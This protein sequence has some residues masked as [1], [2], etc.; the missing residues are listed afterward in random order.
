MNMLSVL[1]TYFLQK[2]LGWLVE[3]LDPENFELSLWSG[4]VLLRNL[5]VKVDALDLL[6]L[7][8][9]VKS[10][11]LSL[12]RLKIPWRSLGSDQVVVEINGLSVIAVPKNELDAYDPEAE[13]VATLAAKEAAINALEDGATVRT[14][15]NTDPRS[16]DAED[17]APGIVASYIT[18]I[19]DNCRVIISD[20][21]V[22][23]EDS[24]SSDSPFTMGVQMKLL[25]LESVD[26]QWNVITDVTEKERD[27]GMIRKSVII[28]DL[29]LYLDPIQLDPKI[30]WSK[31]CSGTPS[32]KFILP[33]CSINVRLHVDDSIVG[34]AGP[35][36]HLKDETP[37]LSVNV[38]L[39]NINLRLSKVQY[40]NIM[41]FVAFSSTYSLRF[42]NRQHRPKSSVVHDPAAWWRYA[43]FSIRDSVRKKLENRS[44]NNLYKALEYRKKYIALYMLQDEGYAYKNGEKPLN[45]KNRKRQDE[46]KALE[47]KLSIDQVK[48]FRKHANDMLTEYRQKEFLPKNNEDVSGVLGLL[49]SPVKSLS[50]I[51]TGS[52]HDKPDR[53]TDDFTEPTSPSAKRSHKEV[54][55]VPQTVKSKRESLKLGMSIGQFSLCID[56]NESFSVIKFT[57]ELNL[58]R[59]TANISQS[60]SAMCAELS[61]GNIQVGCMNS[62][63]FV[64][65]P[66][67]IVGTGEYKHPS[68]SFKNHDTRRGQSLT[69]SQLHS[70]PVKPPVFHVV[71]ETIDNLPSSE[72]KNATA[73]G[74]HFDSSSENGKRKQPNEFPVFASL[75]ICLRRL[76]LVWNS[77]F[78]ESITNFI[79]LKSNTEAD[80]DQIDAIVFAAAAEARRLRNIGE[81]R[82]KDA[83]NSSSRIFVTGS[84]KMPD[85]ILATELSTTL[86]SEPMWS[87]RSWVLIRLGHLKVSS[88]ALLPQIL[89]DI[90][91][92]VES[93]AKESEEQVSRKALATYEKFDII[94]DDIQVLF[95]DVE[96]HE[97]GD[98]IDFLTV[99]AEFERCL[100]QSTV[101][102]P[103]LRVNIQL[104]NS[105]LNVCPSAIQSILAVLKMTRSGVD[106]V[107]E[108]QGS[109][110]TSTM[111]QPNKSTSFH[112]SNDLPDDVLED[113]QRARAE[114]GGAVSAGT[115]QVKLGDRLWL[116]KSVSTQ[117]VVKI[118]DFRVNMLDSYT[119]GDED[120]K[121]SS[122]SYENYIIATLKIM[123]FDMRLLQRTYDTAILLEVRHFSLSDCI[124]LYANTGK[125]NTI[126]GPDD[127]L[128]DK[129]FFTTDKCVRKEKQ[130]KIDRKKAGKR[131]FCT[132]TQYEVSP[133]QDPFMKLRVTIIDPESPS[134]GVKEECQGSPRIWAKFGCLSLFVDGKRIKQLLDY[135]AK[136]IPSAVNAENTETK[137]ESASNED[138]STVQPKPNETRNSKI[139]DMALLLDIDIDGIGL[140]I[141]GSPNALHCQELMCA[142]QNSFR[143]L[144]IVTKLS[145]SGS[146]LICQYW[147][148]DIQV[149]DE[150]LSE[151]NLY[152]AMISMDIQNAMSSRVERIDR[153]NSRQLM[154]ASKLFSDISWLHP[155]SRGPCIYNIICGKLQQFYMEPESTEYPG[156]PMVADVSLSNVQIVYRA[157]AVSSLI[158]LINDHA[159]TLTNP[160]NEELPSESDMDL[161]DRSTLGT[162]PFLRIKIVDTTLVVPVA[163][164]L[165]EHLCVKIPEL[166][167]GNGIGG[168]YGF[169]VQSMPKC[170]SAFAFLPKQV[171]HVD[172]VSCEDI[173]LPLTSDDLSKFLLGS[174]VSGSR[175]ESSAT[176]FESNF[177][178]DEFT[179][180]EGDSEI[181]SESD[182]SDEFDYFDANCHSDSKDG[183][184][185]YSN[186]V[187]SQANHRFSK[188]LQRI[189]K[190]EEQLKEHRLLLLEEVQAELSV[191]N[192]QIKNLQINIHHCT[193]QERVMY[194]LHPLTLEVCISLPVP[195]VSS[196]TRLSL[197]GSK[198]DLSLSAENLTYVNGLIANNFA[199]EAILPESA[200]GNEKTLDLKE[201]KSHMDGDSSTTAFDFSL[202]KWCAEIDEEWIQDTV[203]Y[204]RVKG[205]QV[206]II[207]ELAIS[208]DSSWV[209]NRIGTLNIGPIQV[210]YDADSIHKSSKIIVGMDH[211]VLS[212]NNLSTFPSDGE[213]SIGDCHEYD[214]F[215]L[216]PEHGS[217]KAFSLCFNLYSYVTN[218]H[219]A[220]IIGNHMHLSLDVA[221][222]NMHTCDL[223]SSLLRLFTTSGSDLDSKF[224]SEKNPFIGTFFPHQHDPG[225]EESILP[226]GAS[227]N[228]TVNFDG[229]AITLHDTLSLH[230]ALRIEL[231]LL[232]QAQMFNDNLWVSAQGFQFQGKSYNSDLC[233]PFIVPISF[234]V[235]YSSEGNMKQK[236]K[237]SLV[238]GLKFTARL[239]HYNILNNAISEMMPLSGQER[240]QENNK[241]NLATA[242]KN[243]EEPLSSIGTDNGVDLN[244]SQA[245]LVLD[246]GETAATERESPIVQFELELGP[247]YI[248]ILN[249]LGRG[250]VPL[251]RVIVH[252]PAKHIYNSSQVTRKI[253]QT[254]LHS[255]LS[256]AID[257]FNL[258]LSSWEPLLEMCTMKL[259]AY[260]PRLK[261]VKSSRYNTNVSFSHG[262]LSNL[263]NVE[264]NVEVAANTYYR[265]TAPDILNLNMS[266]S[267]LNSLFE[268]IALVSNTFDDSDRKF[269]QPEKVLN[270]SLRKSA[271]REYLVVENGLG[272]NVECWISEDLDMAPEKVS[273]L[274]EQERR[275]ARFKMMTDQGWHCQGFSGNNTVLVKHGNA[276]KIYAADENAALSLINENENSVLAF[277]V[278]D[279]LG[280]THPLPPIPIYRQACYRRVIDKLGESSQ[281]NRYKMSRS[282]L[283]KAII[284]GKEST[285]EKI[286][287]VDIWK[288]QA[289][290]FTCQVS[291]DE[292]IN[293]VSLQSNLA[294]KNTLEIGICIIL[295][296]RLG[297]QSLLVEPGLVQHLPCSVFESTE[298][299]LKLKKHCPETDSDVNDNEDSCCQLDIFAQASEAYDFG[300][301]FASCELP[302]DLGNFRACTT[303]DID[304]SGKLE[305]I[306]IT[307]I[308]SITI[309]NL[310]PT[311]MVYEMVLHK[312]SSFL[313]KGVVEKGRSKSLL[314]DTSAIAQPF[315]DLPMRLVLSFGISNVEEFSKGFQTEEIRHISRDAHKKIYKWQSVSA[316]IA[317]NNPVSKQKMTYLEIEISSAWKPQRKPELRLSEEAKKWVPLHIRV[318]APY[319]I[320]NRTE[321]A[322]DIIP[323]GTGA[324]KDIRGFNITDPIILPEAMNGEQKSA[325][326]SNI[327]ETKDKF[328][329]LVYGSGKKWKRTSK[330]AIRVH[331]AGSFS[332]ESTPIPLLSVGVDQHVTINSTKHGTFSVGI[333]VV[334]APSPFKSLIVT[335]CPRYVLVNKLDYPIALSQQ[336]NFS[337][338]IN[339]QPQECQTF[340]WRMKNMPRHLSVKPLCDE[341]VSFG[342]FRGK[343]DYEWSGA[344]EIDRVATNVLSIHGW[345][346]ETFASKENRTVNGLVGAKESIQGYLNVSTTTSV[347]R[348]WN[349]INGV[350]DDVDMQLHQH[351]H[352]DNEN[353]V[354]SYPPGVRSFHLKRKH[355]IRVK[356]MINGPLI[357][358]CFD[359][360]DPAFPLYRI[361][362]ATTC[363]SILVLQKNIPSSKTQVVLP[364]TSQPY[365][366]SEPLNERLLLIEATPCYDGSIPEEEFSQSNSR[367]STS[368]FL[369]KNNILK[370]MAAVTFQVGSSVIE[371]VTSASEKLYDGVFSGSKI[372]TFSAS[373]R[374][375]SGMGIKPKLSPSLREYA[376]DEIDKHED[377]FVQVGQH[378]FSNSRKFT[379]LKKTRLL[380]ETFQDGPTKV[381]YITDLPT[382][383]QSA[384][385]ASQ[386]QSKFGDFSASNEGVSTLRRR[387][388]LANR[389]SQ[390]ITDIESIAVESEYPQ[391]V[392][393]QS[394][395]HFHHHS[396]DC[397]PDALFK[398]NTLKLH[399]EIVCARDLV[400]ADITGASDPYAIC[401]LGSERTKP[402]KTNVHQ[403]RTKYISSTLYPR[404]YAHETFDVS[405]WAH[406]LHGDHSNMRQFINIHVWDHDA[407]SSHDS[408]GI[409]RLPLN[410]D[411]LTYSMQQEIDVWCELSPDETLKYRTPVSGDL[412][413]RFRIFDVNEAKATLSV[414]E[415]I[416]NIIIAERILLSL[417]LRKLE[418]KI[419]RKNL[420]TYASKHNDSSKST[421]HS[422]DVLADELGDYANKF[423]TVEGESK[424]PFNMLVEKQLSDELES[425]SHTLHGG[426]ETQKI[427]SK[428][429]PCKRR[430]AITIEAGSGLL[431]PSAAF[432]LQER[433]HKKQK[434]ASYEME[435]SDK[436]K[437]IGNKQIYKLDKKT[438]IYVVVS[439]S[440]GPVLDPKTT[441]AAEC[442][443]TLPKLSEKQKHDTGKEYGYKQEAHCMSIFDAQ[444][445][446]ELSEAN[447]IL[448]GGTNLEM[449][450]CLARGLGRGR[451]F[452]IGTLGFELKSVELS[453]IEFQGLNQHLGVDSYENRGYTSDYDDKGLLFLC[454]VTGVHEGTQASAQCVSVG[455]AL[456]AINGVIVVGW[457]FERI[458]AMLDPFTRPCPLEIRFAS[459]DIAKTLVKYLVDRDLADNPSKA[460]I[461]LKEKQLEHLLQQQE[462]F[463]G[464]NNLQSHDLS[465]ENTKL[466]V[467]R[468][469]QILF[470]QKVNWN[471]RII[472]NEEN[473]PPPPSKRIVPMRSEREEK[474]MDS[475]HPDWHETQGLDGIRWLRISVYCTDPKSLD[476]NKTEETL[477]KTE[478]DEPGKKD[479]SSLSYFFGDSPALDIQRN[480]AREALD[481]DD[482]LIGQTCISLPLGFEDEPEKRHWNKLASDF[483]DASNSDTKGE[484]NDNNQSI[485]SK[486]GF[487]LTLPLTLMPIEMAS[488][489]ISGTTAEQRQRLMAKKYRG[490]NSDRD[491]MHKQIQK[492]SLGNAGEIH[493]QLKWESV[494]PD[495]TTVTKL[496]FDLNVAGLGLSLIDG[497]PKELLYFS[498][499]DVLLSW[500]DKTREE[501]IDVDRLSA[502]NKSNRR[503]TVVGKQLFELK[504]MKMQIDNQLMDAVHPVLFCLSEQEQINAKMA[505]KTRAVVHLS[506]IIS[507]SPTPTLSTYDTFVFGVQAF[508]VNLDESFL[509]EIIS[510]L[511]G[512]DFSGGAVNDSS[513][514][515]AFFDQPCFKRFNINANNLN[516]ADISGGNF[517]Y[518]RYLHIHPLRINI[519]FST[520]EDAKIAD[521]VLGGGTSA[522]ANPIARLVSLFIN[523]VGG[524]LSNIDDAPLKLDA[525]IMPHCYAS[526]DE[527][528]TLI[529]THYVSKIMPQLLR[530]LIS[531]EVLGNP[532][533][534]IEDIGSGVVSF[535]YEPAMGAM[536]SPEMA[537]AGL[538]K[539]TKQ[540]LTSSITGLAN[541]GGKVTEA[542]TKIVSQLAMDEEYLHNRAKRQK[543]G[544]RHVGDGL[545]LG[546]KDLG[547]GFYEGMKG[548]LEKPVDGF[549]KG[550]VRGLGIGVMKGL[551]GCVVKPTAGLM[552]LVHHTFIGIK[553]TAGFIDGTQNLIMRARTPRFF[554][555]DGT[556]C[557]YSPRE[558]QGLTY[559]ILLGKFGS[560]TYIYHI[561]VE[562]P[563]VESA[564]GMNYHILLATD[565]HVRIIVCKIKRGMKS[566][567]IL[568]EIHISQIDKAVALGVKCM[569]KLN[570][571]GS[572]VNTEVQKKL[573]TEKQSERIQEDI[574][575]HAISHRDAFRLVN[576]LA[577]HIAGDTRDARRHAIQWDMQDKYD[578]LISEGATPD[579]SST[580]KESTIHKVLSPQSDKN[581]PIEYKVSPSILNNATSL[582]LNLKLIITRAQIVD[583]QKSEQVRGYTTYL[584][585][586]EAPWY[587]CGEYLK[588]SWTIERRFREFVK[589]RK[590][591]RHNL[592]T[593]KND[594]ASLSLANVI[595]LPAKRI[596][597]KSKK[598]IN[599]R[600]SGLNKFCSNVLA[601][602]MLRRQILLISFFSTSPA[603]IQV[604]L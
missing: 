294:V 248:S 534:L 477:K 439:L 541:M 375:L 289:Y 53:N 169:D 130:L 158:A 535:F 197:Y 199:E 493:I 84:I 245:S 268:T 346:N 297:L 547:R 274:A 335:I 217:T 96:S 147:I 558:S 80:R 202:P 552:D 242:N 525:L 480:E 511:V 103:R 113:L 425:Q 472:F 196:N 112:D 128:V 304:A 317:L 415:H 180:A 412:R 52:D 227:S 393:E 239:S 540:I 72:S 279:R 508:D 229:I 190:L 463:T 221:K 311:K 603:K 244:A 505:G 417:K 13:R 454:I 312:T 577:E 71:Y 141:S 596:F 467:N 48:A 362:N 414:S 111:T 154:V 255:T 566:I 105:R 543:N 237:I 373:G 578:F 226:L 259:K 321:F 267:C 592:K 426:S 503:V 384:I 88:N 411:I 25:S 11:S 458:R 370:D 568:K 51:F 120:P 336:G 6:G 18:S 518:F 192:L 497:T 419:L 219:R 322:L 338:V 193:S 326:S 179:D 254:R 298:Q 74:N 7:P 144:G 231:R 26:G 182:S 576:I 97:N 94:L 343:Y 77:S 152:K 341:L 585:I 601:N 356:T 276:E 587:N 361:V 560:E 408:L 269:G 295:K 284:F 325:T 157:Q 285:Q 173:M 584:I 449:R 377:L 15:D 529:T 561:N 224:D 383:H 600:I 357:Y 344:F 32:R 122:R 76:Y 142:T 241:Q 228:Y 510:F 526:S 119:K 471:Q 337:E 288:A 287:F 469:N 487:D 22:C 416:Q 195:K 531:L 318:L 403:F 533:G 488:T 35:P 428:E 79:T 330:V 177:D 389:L 85:L 387:I 61:V 59:I 527:L 320:I 310:L 507:P 223:L 166:F 366:W 485:G 253:K 209:T 565:T 528:S 435:N 401:W 250:D 593:Q 520:E 211:M 489:L 461:Q 133:T 422:K 342:S 413:F 156:F 300:A 459:L 554:P 181:L 189:D 246:P 494:L 550:G 559:L 281:N 509:V 495:I 39:P 124:D 20:T 367:R 574:T 307:F 573:T 240:M 36:R 376:I 314:V 247:I 466:E 486:S 354:L 490:K 457:T 33:P 136:C 263:E 446:L 216:K 545:I 571:Q 86:T 204:M 368:N 329:L 200:L 220:S 517:V 12:L 410:R 296:T 215:N 146:K 172:K 460:V 444:S 355:F 602:D 83:M 47:A 49:M 523:M 171:L 305:L 442:H 594:E 423:E 504:I 29:S 201:D 90:N 5:K 404:W 24:S 347:L 431:S 424:Q 58:E 309:K 521:I 116:E 443:R 429:I 388:K 506:S 45:S 474:I 10:G 183:T 398:S 125:Q 210:D 452:G 135:T 476:K 484:L 364:L 481:P 303:V 126:S 143:I 599:S 524:V 350:S 56:N 479:I 286:P 532:I 421:Y 107:G 283:A 579:L 170:K 369:G 447:T 359:A 332:E 482:I 93:F 371:S 536:Q 40:Q 448:G 438:H 436:E 55:S 214:L 115:P 258:P 92:G 407:L 441:Q 372:K 450:R 271:K 440:T 256:L 178:E 46:L 262:L 148:N 582:I 402:A 399:L 91:I 331:N 546:S 257:Y 65:V 50:N 266:Q 597:N 291:C 41:N 374:P 99:E 16:S 395:K 98:L 324:L 161:D 339:I 590:M 405:N 345:P 316:H 379:D 572:K 63:S 569:F 238:S 64:G 117:M 397:K 264:E 483:L 396:R 340:N 498:I 390:C 3:G 478:K 208:D 385:Y 583:I 37:K 581:Q 176:E 319:W 513:N 212:K 110:P 108:G 475:E 78:F 222:I 159:A 261:R 175:R 81:A 66:Q 167:I 89:D 270:A 132:L 580:S 139:D 409:V 160:E 106:E 62:E 163:S 1:A 353:S 145:M 400:A 502:K 557:W 430:L 184:D 465:Q 4:E 293:H 134:N 265:I 14:N 185:N 382:A 150:M 349:V 555:P 391:S 75:D 101:E 515:N 198:L 437:V 323:K 69:M 365:A 43:I 567:K 153:V 249:D 137:S 21:H 272:G 351:A 233:E 308:P 31:N 9:V 104:P 539:G 514:S 352:L 251:M 499:R 252:S 406:M 230:Q 235:T 315:V 381:I 278:I 456:I 358:V 473:I 280:N 114:Y 155:M 306:E 575:V 548:L 95:Y 549:K 123:C 129:Y 118:G 127:E 275:H 591:L 34:G 2:Y 232:A 205:I 17:Q 378:G 54:D 165:D 207:E 363:A 23:L 68:F 562:G 537:L 131:F 445:N 292:G 598:V 496:G 236:G 206:D 328:P 553:N 588:V 302:N 519:T 432:E 564:S 30:S 522:S 492:F 28:R 44:W 162:M 290:E 500:S 380:V 164:H 19:V 333:N 8:I 334:E 109:T 100:A 140:Y 73:S 87:Q 57:T 234:S 186:R 348:D 213:N 589:L 151:G 138:K 538:G 544:P 455:E 174:H 82:A 570:K 386:P 299:N 194:F 260:M 427:D 586:V 191:F 67:I 188:S 394:S 149:R 418:L 327:K 187:R 462:E 42:E 491:S 420:I 70:G 218:D 470:R 451:I 225:D 516:V 563:S 282:N 542:A 595:K 203:L 530:I 433:Y 392:L 60:E 551:A 168:D 453:K 512:L 464:S 313:E 501:K 273:H 434:N 121:D 468:A 243:S 556:L 102:T 277:Q 301:T 27:L 604:S 360:V 38:Q